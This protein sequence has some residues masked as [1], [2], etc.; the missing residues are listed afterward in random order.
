MGVVGLLGNLAGVTDMLRLKCGCGES[1][2]EIKKTERG[3]KLLIPCVFCKTHHTYNLSYDI[4]TRDTVTKLS[5]PYANMDIAFIGSG[6]DVSRELERTAGE[7]SSVIA[8]FEGETLS[9]IQPT[10]QDPDTGVT[11][12]SVWDTFNFILR[13]LE[14]EGQVK[15]PCG[16]GKYDLRFTDEGIE[17]F[18]E[19]CGASA[20]FSA[21]TQASAEEYLSLDSLELK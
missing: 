20:A 21:K 19:R 12:P 2:L 9:D 14:S 17:I 8:S 1:A 4:V 11:D 16:E 3:I 13:D 10:D 5:C 7:L 6:D 18:C 15:C